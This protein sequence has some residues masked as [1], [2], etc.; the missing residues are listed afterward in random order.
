MDVIQNQSFRLAGKIQVSF[1]NEHF[2]IESILDGEGADVRFV[3]FTINH[4]RRRQARQIR[5][6]LQEWAEFRK[7][8]LMFI[9][10]HT[11]YVEVIL[12]EDDRSVPEW[13]I[14]IATELYE[15]VHQTIYAHRLLTDAKRFQCEKPRRP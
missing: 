3:D 6:R 11:T 9:N 14:K 13:Q 15:N 4:P 8:E 10:G 7:A 12:P 2:S 5:V 1:K